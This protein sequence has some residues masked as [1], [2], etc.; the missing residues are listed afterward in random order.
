M[1]RA[2]FLVRISYCNACITFMV[3][4]DHS[5]VYGA[6]FPQNIAFL[7][8]KPMR[9]HDFQLPRKR[10]GPLHAA[11]APILAPGLVQFRAYL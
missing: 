2:F 3:T 5:H 6:S 1:I 11:A 8:Q 4:I 10:G 7:R 9:I